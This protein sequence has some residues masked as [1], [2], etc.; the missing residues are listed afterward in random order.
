MESETILSIQN[1]SLSYQRRSI[2]KDVSFDVEA[3]KITA[4]IGPNGAGKSTTMRVL[5]GLVRPQR[6]KVAWKGIYLNRIDDLRKHTGYLID[7]PMFH[8]Y[9]TGLQNLEMLAS[10]SNSGS[11]VQ[12]LLKEVGLSEAQNKKVSAYSKG[13]KQRLG[14]AQALMS[15]P[16]FLI[17]DE[18]FHGLDPDIKLNLMGLIREYVSNGLTV[19][20][21]SHLLSDLERLADNYVLIHNGEIKRKG[22]VQDAIGTGQHVV[23]IFNKKLPAT[24]KN[25]PFD[26][27]ALKVADNSIEAELN[28]EQT[29]QLV[30]YFVSI[31]HSPYLVERE[32]KLEKEYLSNT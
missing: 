14:I 8:N 16:E 18:P 13:M 31:G 9:F 29:E 21:T 30:N 32:N 5:A 19:L 17:L 1:L 7:I 24:L 4:L 6:G 23:F 27:D 3:G 20:I 26:I 15:R 28:I 12:T 11:E 10:L 22:V 25:C 2:L